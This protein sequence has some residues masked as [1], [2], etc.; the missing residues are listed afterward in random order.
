VTHTSDLAKRLSG[1]PSPET[2]AEMFST[3]NILDEVL[4]NDLEREFVFRVPSERKGYFEQDEL[5]GRRVA[6]A[7][8][9][10]ARDIQKAGSCYAMGQEDACVHHLMLVLERGLHS[11]AAKLNVPYQRTNWQDIIDRSRDR[12]K[13]RPRDTDHDIY[14]KVNADFG[15]LKDAYRNHSEHSHD[16]PYDMEKALSI[17][18]HA[19]DFMQELEKGGLSE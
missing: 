6:V 8:P 16:D 11:L 14:R 15:F 4:S 10:C 1:K 9:S 19:R 17:L 3:V 13:S 5:F 7:F 2:Y 18:N 12:L